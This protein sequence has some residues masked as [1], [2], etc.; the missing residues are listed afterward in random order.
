MLFSCGPRS[1]THNQ[2][3][4][5]NINVSST[6]KETK[7]IDVTYNEK[8][9]K[10]FKQNCAVCHI[11]GC[12]DY[13]APNLKG[14]QDRLP[15]PQDEWFIKYTL[16]NEKVYLS[17]DPYAIKLKSDFKDS[18]MT[19]FEGVLTEQDIREIYNFLTNAM[20]VQTVH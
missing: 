19:V 9:S 13:N 12:G 5:D 20:P 4:D 8:G 3:K 10:L 18:P 15:S 2:E 14:I 17:G 11:K 7:Q 6:Q 16:N 1:G